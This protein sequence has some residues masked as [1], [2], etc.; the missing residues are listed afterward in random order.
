MILNYSPHWSAKK[1]FFSVFYKLAVSISLKLLKFRLIQ[2]NFISDLFLLQEWSLAKMSGSEWWLINRTNTGKLT[3]H[4]RADNS[5]IFP[6]RYSI[7]GGNLVK[8]NGIQ[9]LWNYWI[10]LN[11]HWSSLKYWLCLHSYLLFSGFVLRLFPEK[12]SVVSV[13]ICSPVY[14]IISFIKIDH[15]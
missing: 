12:Y 10:L 3:V 2:L 11:I 9:F 8:A 15:Y 7:F 13:G 5:Y 1:P 4:F 6:N 14:I